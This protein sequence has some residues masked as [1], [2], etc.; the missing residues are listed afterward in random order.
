MGEEACH[1][2]LSE[3]FSIDQHL[4][5]FDGSLREETL[6]ARS[7]KIEEVAEVEEVVT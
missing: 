3:Q 1:L 4:Q 2:A 5:V 7:R 6:V